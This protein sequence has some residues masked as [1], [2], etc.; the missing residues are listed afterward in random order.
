MNDG[1]YNSRAR[2][3]QHHGYAAAGEA[4]T[5]TLKHAA[6][7]VESAYEKFWRKR[8]MT[9]PNERFRNK[10]MKVAPRGPA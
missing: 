8:G 6:A 7:Q 5:T 9:P 2:A 4:R 10:A 1:I 3:F